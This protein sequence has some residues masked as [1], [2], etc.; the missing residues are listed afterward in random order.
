MM[1]IQAGALYRRDPDDL[2]VYVT[3]I[4]RGQVYY[5]YAEEEGEF[6]DLPL[7]QFAK[8]VTAR[9]DPQTWAPLTTPES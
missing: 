2:P 9:L 8:Q 7:D 6:G 3:D 4:K 5:E 1:E